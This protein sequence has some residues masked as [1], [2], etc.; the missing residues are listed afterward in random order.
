[1]IIPSCLTTRPLKNDVTLAIWGIKRA[2]EYVISF[3]QFLKPMD[4]PDEAF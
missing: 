2:A 3:D 4:I 1:M